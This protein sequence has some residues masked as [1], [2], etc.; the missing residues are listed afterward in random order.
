MNQTG[1]RGACDPIDQPV[2]YP[3]ERERR[4]VDV[5]MASEGRTSRRWKE[6]ERRGRADGLAWEKWRMAQESAVRIR[7]G[8][9][10]QV[11]MGFDGGKRETN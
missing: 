2:V 11:G 7:V 9:G 10:P 8:R 5:E 1:Q 6:E 4:P 3:R